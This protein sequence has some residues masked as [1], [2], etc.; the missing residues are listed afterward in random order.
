MKIAGMDAKGKKH[1][2]KQVDG[3]EVGQLFSI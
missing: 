1:G 2:G 3:R